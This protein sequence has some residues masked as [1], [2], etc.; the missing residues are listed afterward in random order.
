MPLS[1]KNAGVTHQRAMT[2][3]FTICC[4]GASRINVGDIAVKS[5]EVDQH[6]D[7]LRK[8]FNRCRK[9]NLRTNPLKCASGVSSRKFLGFTV[10]RKGIDLDPTKA[11]A[12]RDMEPQVDKA[13][14][15]FLRSVS[16]IKRF[17]PGF[18]ELL[19]PFQRLLKKDVTF[20]WKTD[21]QA[22]FQKVK[23]VVGS[24]RNMVS[25]IKGLPKTLY[26]TSINKS[27]GVLLAQEVDGTEKPI[28]YL[29]Q[30]LQGA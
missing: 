14:Q 28:Y 4:M 6:V 30:L 27:I 21:Q 26:L 18:A 13:A 10:H 2:A 23:N 5:K 15:K 29:S 8:V 20:E 19:E 9:Y 11:K 24:S 7:D 12:I 25:P 3:I 17:I 16:Y 1:L 22:A